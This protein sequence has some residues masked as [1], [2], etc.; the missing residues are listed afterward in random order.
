MHF[1][2]LFLSELYWF[3]IWQAVPKYLSCM[4]VFPS[5]GTFN[6][7]DILPHH[8][9]ERQEKE[10][11]RTLTGMEDEGYLHPLSFLKYFFLFSKRWE[12]SLV[13]FVFSFWACY[14]CDVAPILLGKNCNQL[15]L[16]SL[17]PGTPTKNGFA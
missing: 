9:N 17:V 14:L 1:S 8:D 13:S 15:C 11:L 3:T 6:Y 12:S 5:P 4:S 16:G 10:E 7:G 2:S